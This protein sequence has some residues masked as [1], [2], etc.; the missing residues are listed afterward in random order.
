MAKLQAIMT[1]EAV[2]LQPYWRS[3]YRHSKPGYVGWDMHI[4][5]LPQIYKIGMSA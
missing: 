1:E 5:Y 3:L 4:A 2:T